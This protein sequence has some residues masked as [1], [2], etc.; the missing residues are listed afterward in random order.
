MSIHNR[1]RSA[2]GYDSGGAAGVAD[3]G[4]SAA[5]FWRS[6]IH[7][8]LD[9]RRIGA[10]PGAGLIVQPAAVIGGQ[11]L[12][13]PMRIRHDRLDVLAVIALEPL[14]V[15]R[16]RDDGQRA[17]NLDIRGHVGADTRRTRR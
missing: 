13:A 8:P 9:V 3:S 11:V 14:V 12:L 2:P 17:V 1:A 7:S 15:Q 6:V 5:T 4:R 16:C 10:D